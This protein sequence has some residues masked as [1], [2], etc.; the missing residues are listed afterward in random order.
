MRLE[1][2][3][4]RVAAGGAAIA[5][6]LLA[7]LFWPAPS[8][9]SDVELV[10]AEQRAAPAPAPPAAAVAVPPAPAPAAAMPDG[11]TLHGVM[12][13]GAVIGLADG[14]QSYVAVGR[15]VI[16]GLRLEAVRLH[17]AVLASATTQ[18]RLGFGG[19]ATPVTPSGRPATLAAQ[20]P[21][22]AC[23]AAER[24]RMAA[25]RAETSRFRQA[26]ARR[27]AGGGYTLRP[28]FSLPALAQAGLQPGDTILGVN[29]SRLG[30]EQLDE[31]AWTIANSSRTE[32]DF[33]RNGR[34]TRLSITPRD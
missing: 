28:G 31:L 18:Y 10:P 7:Y 8:D 26:L 12:A 24:R 19:S 22:P 17:H 14:S 5:A 13:S 20:A 25:E 6:A 3:E 34:R 32:I 1:A 2:R 15:E 27:Q 30:P 9:G 21:A 23:D 4:Q 11:L 16:P 29:G 33:E